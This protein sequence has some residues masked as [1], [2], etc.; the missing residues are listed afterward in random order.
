MRA[1]LSVGSS[2]LEVGRAGSTRPVF[3]EPVY[4]RGGRSNSHRTDEENLVYR[5]FSGMAPTSG[6]KS[7]N[8]YSH[9][10][11]LKLIETV[12]GGGI[13]GQGDVAALSPTKFLRCV[14]G[15]LNTR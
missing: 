2:H 6:V 4:A 3:G 14:M 1:E 13:P 5:S 8:P 11:L 10:S 9:S 12:W 7:S 15:T